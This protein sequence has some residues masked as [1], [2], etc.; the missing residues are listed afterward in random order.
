[1]PKLSNTADQVRR[2]H[3]QQPVSWLGGLTPDQ[4]MKRY[5]QKKPLLVRGAFPAFSPPVSIEDV[6]RLACDDLAESRLIQRSPKGK[7]WTLSHGPFEANEIPALSTSHWTILVQQVNTRLHA[8]DTFLDAFRFIPQARLDDLMISV[9]GPD[10][11]IG[12]HVDS[13]D[14]FL[15]QASGQRRWEIAEQ[16]DPTLEDNVPLKILKN[17]TAEQDWVLA[18]G[19]LLYLPP[20]V[21]HRGTAI[22]QSC[23]TW[24]VGFRAPGRVA[25]ADAVWAG[26]LDQLTDRNWQDPWLDATNAPAEVP[27]RLLERLTEQVMKDLPNRKTVSMGIAQ[28]L[29]EPAQQAVFE[30]P[31]RPDKPHRFEKIA[32][33]KGLRLACSSRVLY[34]GSS[35][36]AN[37]EP[38]E[39]AK[40]RGILRLMKTFANERRISGGEL[41]CCTGRT[42]LIP[43]LY[44]MY[45]AGWISYD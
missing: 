44:E 12:A 42:L 26:H 4:F 1:M 33:E 13:Y 38:L 39:L 15:I 7:R 18:P 22:G 21:A 45:L 24:S 5:W 31:A 28:S 35:F 30:P 41:A 17:F 43:T 19:D 25:L 34:Q 27:K 23:M 32:T 37:G 3:R 11:G 2:P 14:V 20:N 10:G 8:A 9:A 6:L 40:D 29:S 16:F 36:F